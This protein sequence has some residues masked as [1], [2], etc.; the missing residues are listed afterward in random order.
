[1]VRKSLI[2]AALVAVAT[3]PLGAQEEWTWTSDRPDGAAPIAIH[4]ARTLDVGELE[5]T[6]QWVQRNFM[7]VWFG[8]DSLDLATTLQLYEVAPLK[9]SD[10]RQLV[11][12]AYG[13]TDAITIRAR[14]EFALF[15]RE[16]LRDNGT[17]FIMSTNGLGDVEADVTFNVLRQGAYR[18]DVTAGAVIPLGKAATYAESPYSTPSEEATPYDMRPGAG[19][20]GIFGGV[21]A[22]VQNEFGSLGAQFRMRTYLDENGRGYTLGDRY[23]ANGWVAYNV[24]DDLAIR[25]GVRWEKWGNID[26]AD[27]F[28]ALIPMRDPMND[29]VFLGGLRASM[30]I[31]LTFVV[32]DGTRLAGHRVGFEAL[33]SLHHDYDGPQLGLDWGI[34]V[35][36]TVPF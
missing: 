19:S 12:A 34:N 6:Y 16:S 7:G 20:F 21:S 24:T 13:V 17:F 27:E 36:Y 28:L 26:G 2:V 3:T 5:L 30:P 8:K 11:Q 14:A 15:E 23:E 35:G 33:Y 25:S 31:G 22:D 10:R 32:P 29:A 1:M 4:G 9:L 18:M